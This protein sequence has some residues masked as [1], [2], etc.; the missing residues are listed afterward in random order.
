MALSAR[1]LRERSPA[2]PRRSKPKNAGPDAYNEYDAALKVDPSL[3][4][5]QQGRARASSRAE[6]VK[7]AAGTD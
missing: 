6:L 3:V 7:L 5:A 4:F 1:G 2:R